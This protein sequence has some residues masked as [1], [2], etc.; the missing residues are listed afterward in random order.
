[1]S[2]RQIKNARDLKTNELIYFKSHAK[3]TYLSDGSTVEDT[4]NN[5]K[6]KD[7]D[8][9]DYVTSSQL[10]TALSGKQDNIDDLANIRKGVEL[11]GN[12]VQFS[13][14]N[15]HIASIEGVI[16]NEGDIY[17]FPNTIAALEGHGDVLATLNDIPE[18]VTSETIEDWGFIKDKGIYIIPDLTLEDIYN[19]WDNG[20][21]IVEC[22]IQS[23][24]IKSEESVICIRTFNT[25]NSWGI[26]PA[27]SS[28]KDDMLYLLFY[29]DYNYKLTYLSVDQNQAE[30][31]VRDFPLYQASDLL[32]KVYA[33]NYGITIPSGFISDDNLIYALPSSANGTEDSI[34]LSSTNVKTINGEIIYGSGDITIDTSST[35]VTDFSTSDLQNVV[36]GNAQSVSYNNEALKNAMAN[37]QTIVVPYYDDI[38]GYGGILVGYYEDFL[39]FS[40]Y[41][42]KGDIY[43]VETS[44]NGDVIL[45][46]EIRL[47][48]NDSTQSIIDETCKIYY[49]GSINESLLPTEWGNAKLLEN[50]GMAN[51][52]SNGS[53]PTD[54]IKCLIFDRQLNYIPM[55]AFS[56][57]TELR[58]IYLPANIQGCG[59]NVFKGCSKLVYIDARYYNNSSANLVSDINTSAVVI[60]ASPNINSEISKFKNAFYAD[61][62]APEIHSGSVA[63]PIPYRNGLTT[64][65]STR[66]IVNSDALISIPNYIMRYKVA[67]PT[68]GTVALLPSNNSGIV[69]TMGTTVCQIALNGTWQWVNGEPPVFE[70]GNTYEINFYD[71][72]AACVTYL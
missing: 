11:A 43:I 23:L 60:S 29:D 12:S 39:Y 45:A 55:N 22:D 15:L 24:L 8:L 49:T 35:Y 4:I 36:N 2:T 70:A 53:A 7:V 38:N 67:L 5:I 17:A 57:Q 20:D 33:D 6:E 59:S 16:T 28:A 65:Y 13:N 37:K 34:L 40:V 62:Y 27:I 69:F 54:F 66:A 47:K 19:T 68:K 9:S 30:I 18:A 56:G 51:A 48:T 52:Y 50:R 25:Q 44:I 1:M 72:R 64:A 46:E 63:H 32:S 21:T 14:K 71:G 61:N 58:T 41:D 42:E 10:S 26:T 31:Y 3:A